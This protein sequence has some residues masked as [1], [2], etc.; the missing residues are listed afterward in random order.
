MI[1]WAAARGWV[2]CDADLATSDNRS[3]FFHRKFSLAWMHERFSH[4][5]WQRESHAAEAG[6]RSDVWPLAN[7]KDHRKVRRRVA[8]RA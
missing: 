7:R 3:F 4:A 1:Q 6:T 8:Q 5:T 2:L